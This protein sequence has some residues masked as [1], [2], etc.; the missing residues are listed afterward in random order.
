VS[1]FTRR[2]REA[3]VSAEDKRDFNREHFAAAAARYDQATVAMSLGRDRAWKRQLVATLPPLPQPVCLDL[4]CGTGDICLQL[5]RRFP[6]GRIVGLDLTAAMLELARRRG[7][8]PRLHYLQGDMHDLPLATASCDLITGSYA[9]R[10]APDLSRAIGEIARVLRPGGR[11]AF[12]DFARAATPAGQ[13]WQYRLLRCWCGLWGRLL[14]GSW[15]VHGYIADSLENFP[16]EGEL[17]QLFKAHGLKPLARRR[18]FGGM[19]QLLEV[20]REPAAGAAAT[21]SWESRSGR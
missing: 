16:A 2:S 8:S 6:H 4:A 9:L 20:R 1:R 13:R 11:A 5:A 18:L 19:L 15:E 7:P 14:S 3:L 10:N 17:D 12:L 21:E